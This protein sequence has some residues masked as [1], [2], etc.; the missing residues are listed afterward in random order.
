M[1]NN[2]KNIIVS[3]VLAVF[4]FGLS[5]FTWVKAPYDYSESERRALASF[6]ELSVET[7]LSGKFM[8]SF[9]DYTL[10]QF[11][12]RDLFR[13]I[14]ALTEF[15]IFN[16]KD[17][18]DLYIADGY[19][20]KLEYPLSE[21]MLTNSA[22]KFSYLYET[23][24]A[25]KGM[26]VYFSVVPDKNYFLAEENGYLSMD[27]EALVSFMKEKTSYMEYID[28][29]DLLSVEDYYRTD[30]HW[31]QESIVD[32]AERLAQKMGVE[33]SGEYTENTVD[34]PFYGVYYGQSALP[35]EPDTLKYLTNDTL[36]NCIVT[37]YNTGIAV[38]KDMYDMEAATGRD[39]YEM[40]LCGS[41]ALLTIENPEAATD[42]ELIIFRDSFGSSLTPLLCEGY[43]KIYVVDIRY[44]QSAML[45]NFIDFNNQDVLFIYSTLLLNSSAAFK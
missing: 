27:Y 43:A 31:K 44:I 2:I 6:P 1:K 22:D 7:I 14:K 24:M 34:S 8:T 38:E 11:P 37:S 28:I 40:F 16:K 35:L 41:D 19:V 42:K 26:N 20:S 12:L 25:D 15:N 9:E 23:Y 4:L 10:D 3:A 36:L 39:P 32:V 13:R 45:G 29:F 21:D 30:T 5:V 17:N 18:N 33:I